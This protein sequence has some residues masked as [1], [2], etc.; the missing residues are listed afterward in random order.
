MHKYSCGDMKVFFT[1]A[2][3]WTFDKLVHLNRYAKFKESAF[4]SAGRNCL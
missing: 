3:I 2:P 4:S 1:F